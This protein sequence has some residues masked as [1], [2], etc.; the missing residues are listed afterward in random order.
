M[1]G[2]RPT[3][4]VQPLRRS[5]GRLR[6]QRGRAAPLLRDRQ[7][8]YM[9]A[10]A[11]VPG[12]WPR[13]SV[14]RSRE[15]RVR[16]RAGGLVLAPTATPLCAYP[17]DGNSMLRTCEPLGGDGVRCIPGCSAAGE[18]CQ[19]VGHDWSCSFG[20]APAHGRTAPS[21]PRP[22]HRRAAC[23][24]W[25]CRA[26]Y[27]CWRCSRRARHPH[28]ALSPCARPVMRGV[29]RTR[30]LAAGAAASAR[31]RGLPPAQQRGRP[32]DQ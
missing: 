12:A 7:A 15:P 1:G 24:L 21:T 11:R 28:P 4:V 27:T 10:G 8:G 5:V 23:A 29:Q 18:Q 6:H 31:P 20:C 25:P 22:P 14:R 26:S 32:R 9:L 30:W 2:V 17:E 19:E 3:M 16:V 13:R